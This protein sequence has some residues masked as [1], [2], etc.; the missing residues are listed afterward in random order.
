MSLDTVESLSRTRTVSELVLGVCEAL[1]V[2]LNKPL[3]ESMVAPLGNAVRSNERICAGTSVSV[4][5]A[6]KLNVL[7]SVTYLLPIA[8]RVGGVLSPSP[9]TIFCA[10]GVVIVMK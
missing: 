10:R 2:Q 6:V 3:I 1:G 8:E 7:P 4:A 9:V 5:V